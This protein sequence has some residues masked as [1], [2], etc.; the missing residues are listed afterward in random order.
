[1]KKK[2]RDI[3]KEITMT[4]KAMKIMVMEINNNIQD[5]T[6]K[7]KERNTKA[8]KSIIVMRIKGTNITISM[9]IKMI[10]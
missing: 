5:N 8:T 1:M 9:T 7:N 6:R 10:D 2:V 3:N 4:V